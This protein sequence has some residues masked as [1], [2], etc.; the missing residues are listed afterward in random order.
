MTSSRY[1][2]L[3]AS[4]METRHR[5]NLFPAFYRSPGAGRLKE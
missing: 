2:T 3:I 5:R 4:Q 1:S